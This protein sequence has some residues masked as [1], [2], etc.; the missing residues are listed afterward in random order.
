MG[1]LKLVKKFEVNGG[2][3]GR[4]RDLVREVVLPYQENALNDRIEGAEKSHSIENFHIAAKKMRTGK[5]GGEFYG[6]VFQDSDVAKW[7]EGVAYSLAQ[8]PDAQL[9]SRCDEIIDLMGQDKAVRYYVWH[10]RPYLP[11]FY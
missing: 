2:F 9:E 6:M 4:Y 11:A 1:D 8:S 3:F 5:Y 10:G 7:L